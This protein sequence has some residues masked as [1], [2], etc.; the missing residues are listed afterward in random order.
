MP[1]I[2]F[3]PNLKFKMQKRFGVEYAVTRN[4]FMAQTKS[5]RLFV[6]ESLIVLHS[7]VHSRV[8]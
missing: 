4:K 2:I 7:T 3:L 8:Q 6:C 1:L 5:E